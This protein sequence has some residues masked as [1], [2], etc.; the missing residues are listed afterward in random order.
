[1]AILREERF[2]HE[3]L[4]DP[5]LALSTFLEKEVDLIDLSTS[6]GSIL[7]EVVMRGGMLINTNPE[8]YASLLKRMW[9]EKE[10]DARYAEKTYQERLRLWQK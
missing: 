9:S 7:E 10:D 5:Q 2:T 6:H 4:V 1:L 8:L 3:D